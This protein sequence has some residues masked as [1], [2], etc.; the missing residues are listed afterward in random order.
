MTIF[1]KMYLITAAI[2]S[3]HSI[4]LRVPSNTYR[5]LGRSM[6]LMPPSLTLIF[7]H[8][9]DRVWGVVLL[10][11]FC[12]T[13]WVASPNNISPTLFTSA[14]IQ[15]G[16]DYP[17]NKYISIYLFICKDSYHSNNYNRP[18]PAISIS[19]NIGLFLQTRI[20]LL[21]MTTSPALL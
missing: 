6:L 17:P 11:F 20:L 16:Y 15:L 8:K 3:I 2:S 5:T 21:A 1:Q 7:R 10:T 12:W 14:E 19:L 13:H 4:L 18:I 9:L